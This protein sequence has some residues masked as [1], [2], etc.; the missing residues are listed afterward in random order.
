LTQPQPL[1]REDFL[2]AV[3]DFTVAAFRLE[4]QRSYAEPEEDELYAE[5]LSGREDPDPEVM[6]ELREWYE[7]VADH[8][9]HG[10]QIGRVR[11]QEDPP[12]DYQRF[13]RALDRWNVRAGEDMRYLTVPHAFEIGLLPAAGTDDWWLLDSSRLIVMRFGDEGVR[14]EDEI[15]TDAAAVA[16]ACRW[17]D[18][19][20]RHSVR[21]SG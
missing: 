15:V 5:F 12:T 21:A 14:I 13:E 7:R 20:V 6:P 16:R 18:L 10:R 4:L 8:V 17:R 3:H 19:A 9:A 1:A 2:P 11:V